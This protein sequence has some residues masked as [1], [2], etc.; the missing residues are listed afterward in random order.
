MKLKDKVVVITGASSGIGKELAFQ[1]AAKGAKVVL[2]AR[3]SA[4]LNESA[5]KI[6]QDGGV[7]LAIAT[8]VTKR[9]EVDYLVSQTV[10]KFG[11]IDIFINNAGVT[12]RSVPAAELR[13][14]EVKTVMDTNFT[15]GLYSLWAVVPH[16]EK[17]GGGQLVFVSSVVGKRGIPRNA[18]YCASKFAL[19]GFTESIRLEL[20]RKNIRVINVCPPGVNT[21][22]YENNQRGDKR[23]FFLQPVQKIARLIVR[24]SEKEQRDV[25]LTWN[26]KALHY[27]NVFF[28]RLT[29]WAIAKNKGA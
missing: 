4:A 5:A 15:S 14:E 28:P 24:A 13:E 3:N 16:M 23:T 25:L 1:F 8:D 21:P 19:Q 12:H 11:R 18:I 9:A 26:S 10:K 6:E 20:K 7:A 27:A 22:F 29:D 2:A 17:S